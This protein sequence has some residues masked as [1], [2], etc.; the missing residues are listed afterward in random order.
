MS[1]KVQSAIL[2]PSLARIATPA[3]L[4]IV[5]SRNTINLP[6]SSDTIRGQLRNIDIIIDVTAITA[7]PSIQP[8]IDAI[9]PAS[10][11]LYNL[12]PAISSV[13]LVGTTVYRIGKDTVA[14]AGLNA[15]TFLPSIIRII[16]T[17]ADADSITYSVGMNYEFDVEG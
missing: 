5:Q 3:T 2:L 6:G 15:Q 10:S 14:A 8:T 17:H 16:F 4:D 12:L 11:K 9:D 13:T 1:S 7:T